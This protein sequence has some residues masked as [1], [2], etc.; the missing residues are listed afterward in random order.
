METFFNAQVSTSVTVFLCPGGATKTSP[1]FVERSEGK[2][3]P[4]P[5]FQ[6]FS[7]V[8]FL[9]HLKEFRY[10]YLRDNLHI[11]D[12]AE[13]RIKLASLMI[14][15]QVVGATISAPCRLKFVLAVA[16]A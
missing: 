12:E 3:H 1:L 14:A 13:L 15:A 16:V 2:D 8:H 10:Y 7:K 5:S 9:S 11:N 6:T 4:H